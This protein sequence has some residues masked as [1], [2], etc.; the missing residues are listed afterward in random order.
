M[1]GEDPRVVVIG[2]MDLIRPLRR[3]GAEVTAVVCDGAPA[4]RS[5]QV[6][7]YIDM[8]DPFEEAVLIER[9]EGHADGAP[10]PLF[11]Q[12]DQELLAI[13]RNRTRLRQAGYRFVLPAAELV[14]ELV[15]KA[16]FQRLA[17]DLGLPVPRAQVVEAGSTGR[18]AID[19]AMIVKPLNR[20]GAWNGDGIDTKAV[21]VADRDELEAL[22]AKVRHS[23]PRLLVQQMVPGGE[24][25]IE[26]YHVYVDRRGQ[27]AGEFTGR[28]VR[29]IPHRFGYTTSLE[30]THEPDVLALGRTVVRSTGLVGVAKVDMKRDPDGRLLV[31]EVNPRF[32]LWH[33]PGALAGVN[34]P[35]LVLA[36]LT[37]APRPRRAVAQ[38]GVRWSSPLAD[39][40]SARDDGASLWRWMRW[41][42]RCD[43]FHDLSLRDPLPFLAGSIWPVVERRLPAAARR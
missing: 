36:D 13:S 34:L 10:A 19:G 24:E 23:F 28:K 39:L 4:R 20:T 26:S 40:R 22:V 7:S 6:S 21:S 3:A 5:N 18:L 25:R 42:A 8:P 16:R 37:D 17:E 33:L 43:S 41:T 31:L 1:T 29:T 14:E 27:I 15:D 30:I 2:D 11:Y 35:G 12:G 38:P 9:L 32:N